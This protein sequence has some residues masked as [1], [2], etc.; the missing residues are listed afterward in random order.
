MM[1]SKNVLPHGLVWF[2][3][4]RTWAKS[5]SAS[6]CFITKCLKFGLKEP[7]IEHKF[8]FT[9]QSPNQWEICFSVSFHIL[10]IPAVTCLVGILN[11]RTWAPAEDLLFVAHVKYLPVRVHNMS[12][13][14]DGSAGDEGGVETGRVYNFRREHRQMPSDAGQSIC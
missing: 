6:S 12:Q 1:R 5:S 9:R 7:Q 10:N 8:S 4:R 14:C 2:M 13:F 11:S 3:L